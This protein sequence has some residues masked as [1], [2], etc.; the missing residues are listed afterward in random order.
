[1]PRTPKTPVVVPPEQL[2]AE[3]QCPRCAAEGI[4]PKPGS[5]Y[6]WT[7]AARYKGG[8][9]RAAWCKAHQSKA[10]SAAQKQRLAAH[11]PGTPVRDK[12]RAGWR[13]STA[14]YR[15]VH[16]DRAKASA[17]KYRETYP[18]RVAAMKARWEEANPEKRRAIR[19]AYRAKQ[20][21]RGV[22]QVRQRER[23][24]ARR[25]EAPEE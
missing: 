20:R 19:D 7:T 8:V 17:K 13:K 10:S 14:T 23:P 24:E 16:P 15:A 4:G 9:R 25:R 12:F 18:D 5:D 11:G 3:Y 6:T 1:M 21:L 2:A 22:P